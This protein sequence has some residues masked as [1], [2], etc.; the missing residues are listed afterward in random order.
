MMLRVTI[1]RANCSVSGRLAA[2]PPGREDIY[3]IYAESFGRRYH[4]QQILKDAQAIVDRAIA[5][6]AGTGDGPLTSTNG[7]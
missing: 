1:Q 2:H 4:L 7:G 6:P 3:K 5:T